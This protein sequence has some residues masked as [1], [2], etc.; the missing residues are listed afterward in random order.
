MGNKQYP[1][2]KEINF[3]ESH[4]KSMKYERVA[5]R[6]PLANS[7][8]QAFI[9][10]K[11]GNIL[12][13]Y[14]IADQKKFTLCNYIVIL[15][16]PDLKIIQKYV[17]DNREGDV[18][19]SIPFTLQL[20]NGKIFAISDRYYFFDKE[21]IAKGPSKKSEKIDEIFFTS[22]E[23]DF[24]EDWDKKRKNPIYR[25]FNRFTVSSL[26]EVKDQKLIY[27][28]VDPIPYHIFF[29]DASKASS[30]SK[31]PLFSYDKT[32]KNGEKRKYELDIIHKSEYYPENIYVI[33]NRSTL[34]EK[35]SFESVLLCLDIDKLLKQEKKNKEPEFVIQVSNSQKI[36]SICEYDKKYILLDSYKNGIYIID[37]DTKQKVAVSVLSLD[38][39]IL[40]SA[41]I[42][43]F[44][45]NVY[46][47]RKAGGGS[48][49]GEMIKL[50]NGL[51]F[52]NGW[53]IDVRE[54]IILL[55]FGDYG[56]KYIATGDYILIDHPDTSIGVFK[57]AEE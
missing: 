27:T 57:D 39:K 43:S 55:D 40:K 37:L 26:I 53:I 35:D 47:Y 42:P 48:F 30:L 28:K 36:Y 3:P 22:K 5:S 8:G 15:S 44:A 14:F 7:H 6:E 54:Q 9:L 45:N 31:I 32:L 41:G 20:N 52:M 10:L 23:Y 18:Y 12:I 25:T 34:P 46:E 56:Q 50:K 49:Y 11:S 4:H 1:R 51:V 29:L 33:G 19:Y 21:E 24:Y 13:T 17:L 2:P 38:K 16:V